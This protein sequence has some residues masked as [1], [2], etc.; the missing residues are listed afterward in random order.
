MFGPGNVFGE[1]EAVYSENSHR[2][3]FKG[4]SNPT[5]SVH[6]IAVLLTPQKGY[7]VP[8]VSCSRGLVLQAARAK[9]TSGRARRSH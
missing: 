1:V 8:D 5:H 3:F 9:T 4:P 2:N 7:Q 6:H